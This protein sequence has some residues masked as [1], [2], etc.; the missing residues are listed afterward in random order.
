MS[1][2]HAAVSLCPVLELPPFSRAPVISPLAACIRR[3][4]AKM[5]LAPV[6]SLWR[7]LPFLTVLVPRLRR[8]DHVVLVEV[9][10]FLGT[11]SRV[12][13]HRE[14]GDEPRSAGLLGVH[15]L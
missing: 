12:V 8:K 5:Q 3:R 4:S 11:E 9:D 7:T 15:C 10:G 14:E 13:H 2:H 6:L 1:R